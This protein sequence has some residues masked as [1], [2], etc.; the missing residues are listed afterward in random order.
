MKCPI[1]DYEHQKIISLSIHYRSK[2]NKTSKELYV[3]LYCN[4]IEPTCK[5]GCGESVKF[6]DTTRG[7]TD[8]VR[9]HS[10]RVKNNFQS[11]KSIKNSLATRQ[12]MLETGEWKPFTSKET[13]EHW[14][15]GLTKETDERIAKMAETIS[16][17]EEEIKKRSERMR[18]GRL[19]GTIQ[20]LYGKDHSQWKGGISCLRSLSYSRLYKEWKLPKLKEANFKCSICQSNENLEVHHNIET[21]SSIL[22]KLTKQNNW[23]VETWKID[24]KWNEQTEYQELK[25]KI[26]DAVANYH[27]E[28][29]V[30]GVVL[31]NKCHDKNHYGDVD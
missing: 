13:G 8:Y 25:N 27:I 1:C 30:S 16:S 2:H 29:N 20:T 19:N 7:F 21:F 3:S 14:S 23:S 9:G 6:L 12:K 28:N 31:C 4:E 24:P 18:L 11:E 22:N 15:K 5:C 10:S 26:A 17:N